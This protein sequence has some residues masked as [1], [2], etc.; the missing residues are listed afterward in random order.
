LNTDK[1]NARLAKDFDDILVQAKVEEKIINKY[2]SLLKN[3]E[4][5]ISDKAMLKGA[6]IVG[7]GAY[8]GSKAFATEPLKGKEDKENL[9]TTKITF[10]DG[11]IVDEE[12]ISQF[13]IGKEMER[14]K[15][16]SQQS[17][18]QMEKQWP[19]VK[20]TL[21]QEQI[22]SQAEPIIKKEDIA[23]EET[24]KEQAGEYTGPVE[25]Q[26]FVPKQY[27]STIEKYGSQ[28]KID[29]KAIAALIM[30]EN[31]GWD[32]EATPKSWA[33][34]STAIGLGQINN[35]TYKDIAKI[36]GEFDR[37]DPEQAI[38][39]VV[40]WLNQLK[41]Q[42]KSDKIEDIIQA[43]NVGQGAFRSGKRNPAYLKTFQEFYNQ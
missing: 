16:E 29:P 17:S 36:I 43:Y 39:A 11:K 41:K 24:P 10:K 4:G 7:S 13:A 21:K 23:V 42:I 15:R 18:G 19:I 37:T 26:Q 30:T 22:K 25:Y 32:P 31:R 38:H 40:A 1:T 20:S 12:E 28:Y 5:K 33:P 35:A 9:P 2:K 8:L 27:K 14:A 34:T 3:N 6:A